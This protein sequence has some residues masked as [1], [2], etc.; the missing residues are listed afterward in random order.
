MILVAFVLYQILALPVGI[1]A[2][3]LIIVLRGS[4]ARERLGGG[5]GEA[6]RGRIWLHAASLGEFEAARPLIAAW[7][8]GGDGSGLLLSCTNAIA[9]RRFAERVPPGARVRLAPLDLWPC[10]IRALDRERPTHLIFLETEI[11]PAWIFAASI[12]GIPIAIVSARISSRSFRRYRA[13]RPFLRPFLERIVVI[14]CRT[15]EDLC[16]WVAIGAPRDRCVVWGNTKYDAGLAP[17]PRVPHA[18]GPFIFV[19]GSVRRG[20]EGVLDA[21]SRLREG[22]HDVRLLLAPRHIREVPHW[23]NACIRRGLSCRRLS[24]A[25]FTPGEGSL[26]SL[27][28]G[29][30]SLD[31]GIPP[32]LIVDRI[33]VL[34][35]IYRI[36]DAAFIGGTWI[37]LGGHNLFEPAREGIPVLFGPSIEGVR[38]VA[39]ALLEGAGGITVADSAALATALVRLLT[40]PA[41]GSRMGEAA[42]KA[43]V[44]ISG[45]RG[46]TL[47]GLRDAG[48]ECAHM[49]RGAP[50]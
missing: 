28:S 19:A 44:S 39:E 24:I 14:G 1:V 18:Q 29:I 5:V 8:A 36:A 35:R 21:V 3:I 30:R 4:E 48:F 27:D 40:D 41:E 34:T 37:P 38:D 25:G 32:V 47:A 33:G 6:S 7:S 12:R 23:E 16:R 46:R 10:V 42:R 2:V 11:W 50:E 13:L 22:G 45:A 49:S 20:E 9:R 26:E 17:E 43:A 15:E 31:D